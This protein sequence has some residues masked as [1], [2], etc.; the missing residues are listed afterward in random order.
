MRVGDWY[1][2]TSSRPRCVKYFTDARTRILALIAGSTR[3]VE[4]HQR[5]GAQTLANN[6]DHVGRPDEPRMSFSHLP[7]ALEAASSE[8][9]VGERKSLTAMIVL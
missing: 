9:F 5:I 1:S 2:P 4:K 6:V 8:P 3:L 7:F